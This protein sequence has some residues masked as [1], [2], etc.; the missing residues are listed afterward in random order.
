MPL[1]TKGMGLLHLISEVFGLA[2]YDFTS[3]GVAEVQQEK[4]LKQM[5]EQ[6]KEMEAILPANMKSITSTDS[7]ARIGIFKGQKDSELQT[8]KANLAAVKG[9]QGNT[10]GLIPAIENA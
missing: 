2:Q 3:A 5:L 6:K 7:L 4:R 10:S 8:L 9:I 1:W